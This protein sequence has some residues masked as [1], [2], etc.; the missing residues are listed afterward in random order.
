MPDKTE[1]HRETA[2]VTVATEHK[3]S[4]AFVASAWPSLP[5]HVR[6]TIMLLVEL[7]GGPRR[8]VDIGGLRALP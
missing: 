3:E 2:T 7:K 4:I 5:P 6:E 8:Q 1:A